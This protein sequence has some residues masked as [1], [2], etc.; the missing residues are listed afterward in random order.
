MIARN[1]VW[2]QANQIY[3]Q[4]PFAIMPGERETVWISRNEASILPECE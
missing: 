1:I 2:V 3:P 4:L